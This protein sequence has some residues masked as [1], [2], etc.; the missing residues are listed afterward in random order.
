[1]GYSNQ[2][3]SEIARH[4]WEIKIRMREIESARKALIE[5]GDQPP[6]KTKSYV[7]FS[8]VETVRQESMEPMY[9]SND[10]GWVDL[11]SATIFT[12]EEK[13]IFGLPSPDGSWVELPYRRCRCR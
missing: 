12:A 2:L 5:K 11:S 9:W 6:E 4:N 10:Q 1:M 7:I 13:A 3:P 8:H